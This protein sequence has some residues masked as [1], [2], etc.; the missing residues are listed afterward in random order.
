MTWIVST[1]ENRQ[2]ID[3]PALPTPPGSTYGYGQ[4]L[5]FYNVHYFEWTFGAVKAGIGA[6]YLISRDFNNIQLADFFPVFS[7]HN[8]DITPNNMCL[9]GDLA[10]APLPGLT[11]YLQYGLDDVNLGF[12]GIADSGVPTVDAEVAGAVYR[13]DVAPAWP[14]T[15]A[16][17]GGHTHYLWGNYDYA[18]PYDDYLSRAIFRMDLWS[19]VQE[20]PLTSPF[21]PGAW[22]GHLEARIESPSGWRANAA[23]SL[24]MVNTAVNLYTTPYANN[25]ALA[26]APLS[27]EFGAQLG[28]GWRVTDWL[29]VR[30]GPGV[31]L[32]TGVSILVLGLS[33]TASL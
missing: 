31:W 12:L 8:A 29:D 15:L 22:W 3:D 23:V 5:I 33:G 7:W 16:L 2:G 19:Y 4:T 30:F 11:L 6:Q 13:V 9:L 24:A 14:L 32:Q 1:L 10:W 21:G 26:S 18:A 27:P 17:T 28:V 25:P 20:M